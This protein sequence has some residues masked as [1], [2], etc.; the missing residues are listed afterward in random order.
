VM[1]MVMRRR[2][3]LMMLTARTVRTRVAHHPRRGWGG[4]AV[5]G[6]RRM[7]RR[8]SV[9]VTVGGLRPAM[10]VRI[11]LPWRGRRSLARVRHARRSISG[12]HSAEGHHALVLP[13]NGSVIWPKGHRCSSSWS[14]GHPLEGLLLFFLIRGDKPERFHRFPRWAL[15]FGAAR[16]GT[17]MARIRTGTTVLGVPLHLFHVTKSEVKV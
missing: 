7:A 2:G 13:A 14:L 1:V 5:I 17:V 8:A 16:A 6:V 4:R 15:P 10:V 11:M 9:L 3:W 12:I